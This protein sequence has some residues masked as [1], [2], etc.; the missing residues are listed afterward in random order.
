MTSGD[1]SED[2]AVVTGGKPSVSV[3]F[4]AS[5]VSHAFT[6]FATLAFVLALVVSCS[7][8][9]FQ[10]VKNEVAGYPVV[11]FLK[12]RFA[13]YLHS[14]ALLPVNRNGGQ[15]SRLL[16]EIGIPNATFSRS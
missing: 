10:V 8:H 16:W 6:F 14:Y 11:R 3:E 9:Y 12:S 4:P 2:E 1:D 7:L 13:L 15:Q 5:Y